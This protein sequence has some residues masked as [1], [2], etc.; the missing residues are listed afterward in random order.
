MAIAEALKGNELIEVTFGSNFLYYTKSGYWMVKR[1]K[2]G[3][4]KI[5]AQT[6]SEDEAVR[7]LINPAANGET[8]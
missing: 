4:A 3:A 6:R 5:L 2:Q 8:Q 7:A 1:H